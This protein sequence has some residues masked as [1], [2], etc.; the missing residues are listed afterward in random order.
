MMRK[1]YKCLFSFLT[2]GCFSLMAQGDYPG[3]PGEKNVTYKLWY[4]FD[5]GEG[6]RV[7]LSHFG[8]TGKTKSEY[9]EKVPFGL[10]LDD[11]VQ[12]AG[13]FGFETSFSIKGHNY[14]D[15]YPGNDKGPFPGDVKSLEMW[16]WGG[17]FDYRIDIYLKNYQGYVY[18]VPMGS[19]R[20]Y[21]W[22][23]LKANLPTSIPR[24]STYAS[25]K[26]TLSLQKIRFRSSPRERKD[27]F[28]CAVDYFR[29]ITDQY[30]RLFDG[31]DVYDQ[32][33][34]QQKRK[35]ATEETEETPSN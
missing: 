22:R 31:Y 15:I 29:V 30:K 12:N 35:T 3:G 23:N 34:K 21:G 16:V 2:A 27:I 1:M 25:E 20:Y 28:F 33:D 11:G 17:N 8:I 14:V 18:R 26:G 24:K 4:N 10:V 9:I 13:S 6:W 32:F 19:I 5:E 7:D